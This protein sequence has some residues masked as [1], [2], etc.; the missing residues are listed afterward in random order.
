[1]VLNDTVT[2]SPT[3]VI[4]TFASYGRWK[5]AHIS[6]NSGHGRCVN[7]WTLAIAVPGAD[8]ARHQRRKLLALWASLS[9]ADFRHTL[10]TRTPSDECHQAVFKAHAEFG[11]NF[12]DMRIN[13]TDESNG[14]NT[15]SAAFNFGTA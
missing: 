11:G 13:N 3:W 2:P 7:D 9:V 5:E 15:G 1:M 10:A 8:P 12:D 4:N 6:A 14:V